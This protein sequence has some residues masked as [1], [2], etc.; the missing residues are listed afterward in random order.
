MAK[1]KKQQTTKKPPVAKVNIQELCESRDGGQIALRGYS[2]Q[3]LY[4][5]NLILSSGSDTIFTLEGV[6]DIDTIKCSDGNK[7]IT[8]IQLKFSTQRQDA[9]NLGVE[10]EI[11]PLAS[12]YPIEV[13]PK[14]LECFDGEYALQKQEPVNVWLG[15]IA[16]IGEELWMYSKNREY[17]VDEE[18]EQYLSNNLSGIKDRISGM[19]KGLEQNVSA[20]I[21]SAVMELCSAVYEGDSF[22]DEKYNELISFVQAAI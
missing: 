20:D 18:Y 14:M 5:C 8:H 2:Y 15:R 17:L 1:K 21:I 11:D 22:N 3:F 10:E 9:L 6:E 4:S 12:P 13:T 19:I 7:T 16:D